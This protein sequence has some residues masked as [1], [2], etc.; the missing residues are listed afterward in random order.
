M[1][2]SEPQVIG[3]VTLVLPCTVMCSWPRPYSTL[4]FGVFS[5]HQI[6]HVWVVS[7]DLKLFGREIISEVFQSPNMPQC[8]GRTDGR[9]V[10]RPALS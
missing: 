10:R 5:L 3:L 7:R 8:H 2:L 1:L 9:T 6:A 4:I